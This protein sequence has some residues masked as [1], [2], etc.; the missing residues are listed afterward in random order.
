MQVFFA[1]SKKL[2][3]LW[4]ELKPFNRDKNLYINHFIQ[5]LLNTSPKT[6]QQ[7][8]VAMRN[9]PLHDFAVN[10]QKGV[11][12]VILNSISVYLLTLLQLFYGFLLVY[13]EEF[14]LYYPTS[15]A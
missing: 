14:N 8:I 6:G 4:N 3:L 10:V 11:T 12:L 13:R 5:I 9:S 2:N 1:E 15:H 7:Y